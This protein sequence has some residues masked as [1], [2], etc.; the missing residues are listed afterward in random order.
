MSLQCI[1]EHAS[2]KDWAQNN[3][4]ERNPDFML[5]T[6]RLSC[7]QCPKAVD[8]TDYQLIVI[9]TGCVVLL[10]ALWLWWSSRRVDLIADEAL[11][12][13]KRMRHFSS[14]HT[15]VDQRD[16]STSASLQRREKRSPLRPE[17]NLSESWRARDAEQQQQQQARVNRQSPLRS[18]RS[19]AAPDVPSASVTATTEGA[20][21]SESWRQCQQ[22]QLLLHCRM[23]VIDKKY[24]LDIRT[25]QMPPGKTQELLLQKVNVNGH[26]N[27]YKGSRHKGTL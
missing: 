10:S 22:Q 9:T 21:V 3:E 6:C 15:T 8:V 25:I 12:R 1:D 18:Q 5:S 17:P 4:C 26:W 11:L 2:C 7:G 24:K 19:V 27:N 14:E 13:S 20:D 23:R 16:G